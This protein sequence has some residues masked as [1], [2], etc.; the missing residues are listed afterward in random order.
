MGGPVTDAIHPTNVRSRSVSFSTS[1]NWSMNW[2][3]S[4]VFLDMAIALSTNS[5]CPQAHPNGVFWLFALIGC[6]G[7]VGFAAKMPETAGKTLEEIAELFCD[8][9]KSPQKMDYCSSSVIAAPG[10]GA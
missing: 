4:Q 3:V 10:G 2:V 9:S 8:S 6:V 1:V 7:M 5:D